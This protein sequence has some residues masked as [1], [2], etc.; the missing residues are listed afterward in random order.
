M[1]SA[2]HL[3]AKSRRRVRRPRAR[4]GLVACRRGQAD[5]ISAQLRFMA[6]GPPS[7]FSHPQLPR[8]LDLQILGPAG[9]SIYHLKST[10]LLHTVG[11]WARAWADRPAGSLGI[12]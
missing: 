5:K 2:D 10:I 1:A 8:A 9:L 12:S 11:A 3:Q 4:S 7:G 6:A